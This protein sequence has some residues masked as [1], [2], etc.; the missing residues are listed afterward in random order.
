[1]KEIQ[2]TKFLGLTKA[3][4]NTLALPFTDRVK[5]HVD[6]V[7]AAAQF[8]LAEAASGSSLESAFPEY[9]GKVFAVVRKAEIKYSFPAQTEL[10]ASASVEEDEIL[11]ANEE[12]VKRKRALID[13]HVSLLDTEGQ[14]TFS[15]LFQWFVQILDGT[16]RT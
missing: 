5:N 16:D 10:K 13:V 6:T 3:A 2:I 4:D 7:H 11:K 14:K 9:I 1:M 8:C 15:G 12:L